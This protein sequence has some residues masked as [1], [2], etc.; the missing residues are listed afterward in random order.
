LELT[1]EL[2]NRTSIEPAPDL[3]ESI[4]PSLTSREALSRAGRVRRWFSGHR[5]QSAVG[6][7][8]ASIAIAGLFLAAPG[9]PPEVDARAYFA[10]HAS[11]SWREPFADKAGLGLAAYAPIKTEWEDTR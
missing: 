4:R 8:A 10:N 5:L 1:G 11:M 6:A 2:L 9:T 3:W 7:A